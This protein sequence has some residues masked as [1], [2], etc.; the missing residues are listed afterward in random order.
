[1]TRLVRS[2]IATFVGYAVGTTPSAS[3]AGRLAGAEP[4]AESGTGNPG[5][6]NAAHVLGTTW[7]VAVGAQEDQNYPI[8]GLRC[9][10][11]VKGGISGGW[12]LAVDE[13]Q[14]NKASNN[15]KAILCPEGQNKFCVRTD[16]LNLNNVQCG[17]TEFYGDRQE[18]TPNEDSYCT[19]KKCASTCKEDKA[20][21]HS[22]YLEEY[23]EAK[24]YNRDTLC[25]KTNYCNAGAALGPSLLLLGAVMLV[26]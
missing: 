21:L 26:T 8:G 16:V 18:L 13:P 24:S 25:C 22:N 1:M 10:Y 11:T 12:A 3:I 19:F 23:R 14:I 6:M 20:T 9:Y 7:G 17:W 4:V 15:Q 5:G 2:L